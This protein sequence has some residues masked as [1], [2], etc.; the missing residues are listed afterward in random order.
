[1]NDDDYLLFELGAIAAVNA[2][3]LFF[4]LQLLLVNTHTPQD[5]RGSNSFIR[6]NKQPK[7]DHDEEGALNCINR[8]YLGPTPS[9]GSQFKLQFRMSL[10]RFEKLVADLMSMTD[11]QYTFFKVKENK[12]WR[13][14][15][16]FASKITTTFENICMIWHCYTCVY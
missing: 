14:R 7:F 5:R 13:T 11:D 16:F 2:S 8:D 10:S 4:Q 12:N 9:H 1:M 3:N 6:S 15:V